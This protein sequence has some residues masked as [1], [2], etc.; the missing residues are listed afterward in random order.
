MSETTV[1]SAGDAAQASPAADVRRILL[2]IRQRLVTL[3]EP[4]FIPHSFTVPEGACKV[5]ATLTFPS[6]ARLFPVLFDPHGF[7]GHRMFRRGGDRLVVELWVAPNDASEGGL[8]GP[9][10]AG[11]WRA[12]VNVRAV[13]AEV[14]YHLQVYAEVGGS[15]AVGVSDYPGEYVTKP[16]PG[17]Y[18]GELHA[19][20]T[21]SDGDFPVDVVV[22]A[23][24]DF[25][26]DYLA[27]TD[28]F[29]H[30]PWRKLARLVNDKVALLRSCEIT[31]LWGH[32]NLHGI[33]EWV[34]VFVDRPGWDIN[35][36]ADAVHAQGGLFCVN[37]A[38]NAELGWRHEEFDWDKAD[39]MEIY[40]NLEAANN[41]L[42]PPLWDCHLRQGRRIV[43]VGGIDSHN[44]F[45]GLD[46]L[47][48]VVT[49]VYAPELSEAGI[50]QGLRSGRVYVSRG[51]ELRFTASDSE[52]RTAEMWECLPLEAR[53]VAFEL[54]VRTSQP[55]RLLLLKNGYP[56]QSRVLEPLTDDWQTCVVMDEPARTAYYRVELHSIYH[57]PAQPKLTWRDYATVQV[58]SNPIWVADTPVP[59]S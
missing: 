39:L 11:E 21:E 43:G 17:W 15:Q 23:A 3:P 50:V 9:L 7:R 31:S 56:F 16:Q 20:S 45:R 25:G 10:P 47:G 18:R 13:R 22:Q 19:H 27:L 54:S 4:H 8:P 32:A 1:D 35:Q 37:H 36:A 6:Q 51:P 29:T 42:V 40:H 52:G 44:P 57:S 46:A 33:Q 41:N 49:W 53:P 58:L 5:G 2:D 38:M 59:E 55:L 30:S 48:Q 26:L 24:S 14:E 12:E 34:D 28:H